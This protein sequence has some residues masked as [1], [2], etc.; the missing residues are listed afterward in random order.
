M[1]EKVVVRPELDD[2]EEDNDKD[3]ARTSPEKWV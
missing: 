3:S 1:G 2:E